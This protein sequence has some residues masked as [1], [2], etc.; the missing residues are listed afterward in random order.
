MKN[1]PLQ[2]TTH[3]TEIIGEKPTLLSTIL[4]PLQNFEKLKQNQL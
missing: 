4:S 1:N 2:E 3:S